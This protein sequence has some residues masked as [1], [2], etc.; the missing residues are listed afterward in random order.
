MNNGNKYFLMVV[1]EHSRFQFVFAC[2]DAMNTVIIIKCL[3]S[4]FSL[5]GMPAYVHSDCGAS[6][7][8][9]ELC[10]FLSSKGVAKTTSYNPEGNVQAGRCNG[11]IWKAVTM[12]L[13]SKNLPLKHWQDALPDVLHS[14]CSL[15]CTAT[16]KK[17]RESLFGN[18]SFQINKQT[19]LFWLRQK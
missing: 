11:V 7:M 19:G 13:K 4:L 6:F 1:D 3:T 10:E 18:K 9:R 15:L 5:V 17:E 14:V 12:S 16:Q 8:S 2:S